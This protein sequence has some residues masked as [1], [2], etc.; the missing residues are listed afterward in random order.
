MYG[1]IIVRGRTRTL[2]EGVGGALT[3]QGMILARRGICF[4]FRPMQR[5]AHTLLETVRMMGHKWQNDMN[6]QIGIW[7]RA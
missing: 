7:Q 5:T 4:A 6:L 1:D 2:S 3:Q